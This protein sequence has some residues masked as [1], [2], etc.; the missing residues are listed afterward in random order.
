MNI[1]HPSK[2]M[3]TS[4]HVLYRATGLVSSGSHKSEQC[5]TFAT[6]YFGTSIKMRHSNYIISVKSNVQLY[7][8][9][10]FNALFFS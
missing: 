10:S 6:K 5:C 4:P 9:I 7:Y 8:V 3:E 1:S 2:Q